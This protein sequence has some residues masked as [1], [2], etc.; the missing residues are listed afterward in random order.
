MFKR[1]VGRG[2]PL[3]MVVGA[4]AMAPLY[5]PAA[6]DGADP[7]VRPQDD[8]FLAANGG[9]MKTT[10]IPADKAAYGVFNV[11]ADRADARVRAIVDALAQ[12][13][14]AA[15]SVDEKVAR[16]YRAYTD[17]DAIERSGATPLAPSM[18][19]IAAL[20][21]RVALAR[22]MGE[23]QGV[24]NL[25]LALDVLPDAKQPERYLPALNQAGLGLPNRDYY[26][27]ANPQLALA[28]TAYQAY[29]VSLF[30]LHGEPNPQA[31]AGAVMGLETRLARAQWSEVDVRD[32]LKTWHPMTSPALAK[33]AP[34]VAWAELFGAAALPGLQRMNVG[35]PSYVRAVAAMVQHVPLATWQ[36]YLQARVMD[37][38]AQK[39]PQAW[40]EAHFA[41]HGKALS[42]ATE[43]K[44]RWQQAAAALDAALGEAV[45]QL[46]VARH[47]SPAH[48]ARVQQMVDQL[49]VAYRQSI[50]QAGWLSPATRSRALEKLD[51]ITVKIGFPDQWRDYAAL[52]VR[53]GDPL[54]NAQRAG[55]FDWLRVAGRLGRP[56]D[57]SEWEMT[58]QTVNAYYDPSK[59]EIVFPAAIL[60]PPLF[61]LNGDDAV[62]YAATG[63]TIGHEISHGFDD[64]GSHYDGDGRLRDWWQ[65]A[66]RKA[67]SR[68]GQRLVQQFNAYQPLPG[69]RVNG[70]LTLGENMADLSGL[71]MAYQAWQ[72]S[73]AGQTPPM[74]DGLTGD[75][76][77]FYGYALSFRSKERDESLLQRLTADPH[78]PDDLRTNGM[79]IHL[80]AYHRAFSTQPGDRMFRAPAQR[81]R[82]W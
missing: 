51:K 48:K 45:G 62:N 58:P 50:S 12:G 80:D 64:D 65:P 18:G 4:L 6:F 23:W 11:L 27:S 39:L 31:L 33:A 22:L 35:Q 41:F 82:I 17:L 15:G 78:S 43:A 32:A 37:A 7:T 19:R 70:R 75:Q 1:L 71:Q 61:D 76:R 60:E 46:Y 5:A 40:R 77:F 42:G 49:V 8:L 67:F 68:L 53:E 57:H 16:Y 72:L 63:S 69:H 25:P 74:V 30:R 21:D 54:G 73:L 3:C 81:I 20:Q 56:V 79:V 14:P 44:P 9:W 47:F 29:L 59:N 34:G 55:R 38:A 52:E 26:L 2:L 13:T 10:A 24:V 28:R 36:H 66:D